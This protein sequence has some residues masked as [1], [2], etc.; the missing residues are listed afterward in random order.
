MGSSELEKILSD[1]PGVKKV[2]L[3]PP[4][5]TSMEYPCIRCE[6]SKKPAKYADNKPYIRHEVYRLI[7]IDPKYNSKIPSYLDDM[8]TSSFVDAYKADNLN[9]WV[10]TIF[11]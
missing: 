9:H 2:Y 7:V 1:I 4:K 11:I 10:Y 6:L 5:N 8:P 3:N